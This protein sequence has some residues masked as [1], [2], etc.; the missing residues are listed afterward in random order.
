MRSS[1]RAISRDPVSFLPSIF[2]DG[3]VFDGKRRARR[4]P[5]EITGIRSTRLY[6]IPFS[7]SARRAAIA[8]C[9]PG[10]T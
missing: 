1:S 8:G 4:A 9:E 7:S 6:G 10:I 3:T 2:I 5:R